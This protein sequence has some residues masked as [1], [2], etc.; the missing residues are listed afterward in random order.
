MEYWILRTNGYSASNAVYVSDI[1]AV[2]NRGS[3]VNC[4]DTGVLP[5]ITIDLKTAELTNAG[6]V[7]SDELY[8]EGATNGNLFR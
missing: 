3:Y 8:V 1:G 5:A 2:Y 4:L 6:K 7:S